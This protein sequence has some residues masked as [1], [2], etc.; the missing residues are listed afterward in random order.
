MTRFVRFCL[1]GLTNTAVSYLVFRASLALLAGL[2]AAAGVSQALSYAAG[3]GWSFTWNRRFTFT[4]RRGRFG[5]FTAVQIGMLAASSLAL[6]LAVDHLRLPA[7]PS[8]AVCMAVVTVG[9]FMLLSRY[10]FRA[11]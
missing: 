10:V 1:V 9:N 4:G 8:W 6:W 11:P 3:I 5:T 7:T 2:P